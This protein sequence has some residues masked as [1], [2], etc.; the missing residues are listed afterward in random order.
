MSMGRFFQLNEK[1]FTLIE[2]LVALAVSSVVMTAIYAM[3]RSQNKSYI[4][5]EQVSMM[6]QNMRAALFFME[7][8]IKLAG[9]NPEQISGA[10]APGFAT[11]GAISLQFTLDN[12]GGESDG[13]DNDNDGLIDGSDTDEDRYADASTNDV[14]EDVTYSLV[15]GNLMRNDVNSGV[16]DM[17]AENI[18]AMDFVYLDSNF[19]VL[20]PAGADVASEDL[21]DIRII[22]VTIVGRSARLDPDFRN[23]MVYYNAQG[24]SLFVSPND[25]YRRKAFTISINCRNMGL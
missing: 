19:N 1:G 3:Y 4:A 23:N 13:K 24:R 7:H 6:Q 10:N 18:E 8:D 16:N 25:G 5:Q 14:G 11:A 21:S 12:T 17:I 2:V 20:N 15:G 9:C 22:E